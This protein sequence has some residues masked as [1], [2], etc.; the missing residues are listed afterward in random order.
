MKNFTLLPYTLLLAITFGLHPLVDDD[1][2][3]HL[4]SGR[5]ILENAAIP[6]TDPF[7]YTAL[8]NP[9]IH[10]EWGA[11]VL[12][13][14]LF[15]SFDVFGLN[16]LVVL[17]FWGFLF[18]GAKA[19][20]K[21]YQDDSI[22]FLTTFFLAWLSMYRITARPHLFSLFFLALF[23]YLLLKNK[24]WAMGMIPI[25]FLIWANLHAEVLLGIGV[26]F[27]YGIGQRLKNS[28]DTPPITYFVVA[29]ALMILLNPFT[30]KIY[31]FPF[32]HL[33]MATIIQATQE[34]V[35]PFTAPWRNLFVYRGHA[36][37]AL[38]ILLSV[39]F[40]WRTMGWP[41]LLTGIPLFYLSA[42]SGRYIPEFALWALP[43]IGNQ[44]RQFSG[45]KKL[46]S[47]QK[48]LKARIFFPLSICTL[49]LW[50]GGV[51]DSF[52][53]SQEKIGYGVHRRI[54]PMD[55]VWFLKLNKLPPPIYNDMEFGGYLI[56]S[57]I[58]VFI[59][60]RTPVYGDEFFK[61][62]LTSHVDV[63]TFEKLHNQWHFKTVM[64]SVEKE[65]QA[66][67]LHQYLLNSPKWI[68]VYQDPIAKIYVEQT[69]R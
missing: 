66:E 31:T 65:K 35:S 7:S 21:I 14:H 22:P 39:L 10:H 13:W 27:L 53:G 56:L 58:P 55:A 68:L 12:F 40:R 4:A 17:L 28:N 11:G 32:E 8:G 51:P 45:F 5:Y 48:L 60:G 47:I 18:F 52:A 69:R 46:S 49:F 50:Q 64:L 61:E 29:S 6:D 43:V 33:A 3:W 15:N 36:F 42:R 54:L 24:K 16:L 34:W 67:I 59:D 23:F 30:Y 9:W 41:I 57:G 37:L 62:Y 25:I 1:T 38:L 26:L 20:Q 2:W 19:A 63:P 44:L